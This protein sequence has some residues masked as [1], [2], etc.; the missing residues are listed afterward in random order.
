MAI[1]TTGCVQQIGETAGEVW[2]ILNDQGPTS[3]AKLAKALDCPRDVVMAR[4]DKVEI[5]E[6]NRGRVASLRQE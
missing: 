3:L 4:E 5:E 1:G 6:T 2:Q